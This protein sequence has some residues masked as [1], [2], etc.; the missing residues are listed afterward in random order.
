[1]KLCCGEGSLQR[2]TSAPIQC[3]RIVSRCRRR[4]IRLLQQLI[5]FAMP[6]TLHRDHTDFTYTLVCLSNR[7]DY[8]YSAFVYRLEKKS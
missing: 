5:L 3:S 1:M 7:K 8:L 6:S 4:V 2:Y